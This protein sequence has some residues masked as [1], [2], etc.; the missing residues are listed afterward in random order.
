MQCRSIGRIFFYIFVGPYAYSGNAVALFV[1]RC[2]WTWL[3]VV[4][5]YVHGHSLASIAS[6]A[7]EVIDYVVAHVH[8]LV[9][10]CCWARTESWRAAAVVGNEVVVERGS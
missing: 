2:S 8:T 9:E 1:G 7:A 4:V 10:L 6:V 3:V 5:H